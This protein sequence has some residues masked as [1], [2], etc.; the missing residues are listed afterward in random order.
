[1]VGIPPTIVY[2]GRGRSHLDDTPCAMSYAQLHE[3][4]NEAEAAGKPVLFVGTVVIQP[5]VF[6][7]STFTPVDKA[8]EEEALRA[9]NGS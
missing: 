5:A 4:V 2:D 1:M 7:Q 3:L 6:T 9:A 8:V